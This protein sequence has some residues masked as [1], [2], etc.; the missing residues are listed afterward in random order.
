M[1]NK[2]QIEGVPIGAKVVKIGN[3]QKGCSYI[4]WNG[5]IVKAVIDSAGT[6]FVILEPDND[7]GKFLHEVEAE[8]IA[9]GR[10]RLGGEDYRE[11]AKGEEFWTIGNTAI[12]RTCP[13]SSPVFGNRLILKPRKPKT[14]KFLVMEI[15]INDDGYALVP[16]LNLHVYAKATVDLNPSLCRI[17]ERPA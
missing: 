3:L 8:I 6:G 1:T 13:G 14:K 9:A 17:E 11:P 10:E 2:Q 16:S 7:Y 12:F 4:E 5:K 15:P